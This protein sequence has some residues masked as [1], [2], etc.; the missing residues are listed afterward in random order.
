MD[1]YRVVVGASTLAA[2]LIYLAIQCLQVGRRPK[3]Y[4]PGPPTVP[5]LGNLHLLSGITP[6][7]QERRLICGQIPK[8]KPWLQFTKWAEEYGPIYSLM[9]GT[10]TYIV[11]SSPTVVKDLLDKRSNIY[12]SRPDMYIGQ[13]IAS[14]GLRL[15]VMKY[16]ATW[17]KMHRMVHNIFNMRA[18]TTYLPYQDLE[19]KQML[20]DLLDSPR[21]F[22]E[23]IRRYSNSLT[24]QM[25]FGFRTTSHTD[26]KLRQLFDC[27]E[28]WGELAAGPSSQLLDIY[29][30][31]RRLPPFL[32]PN[33]RYAQGLHKTEMELYLGH[34]MA[35][36]R[37][38]EN[39]TGK[40]CFCNDVLRV[41]DQEKMSDEQAA[42]LSGSLL[43]AGSDTTSALLVGFVQAML[44]F[45][46]VQRHAQVE[47][48]RVV[49]SAR[50][51]TMD[52]ASELPYLR[53]VVKECIRW[54]PTT[55]MAA[56]HSVT[57]EDEYMGYRIPKGATVLINVWALHMDP[58]T[59][60]SP[61]TFDPTRFGP[62]PPTEFESATASDP[63]QRRNYI[64]GAGRRVCQGMH[65][66]ERSLFLAVTRLLW[67]FD[68]KSAPGAT[69]MP[70]VDD[71]VGSL[72]V[73]P[74]PFEVTIQARTKAK[75]KMVREAWED[76]HEG[77]LDGETGQWRNVPEGM[78]FSTWMPGQEEKI[79]E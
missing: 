65:I 35:T 79:G 51:P 26:S 13:D 11:L 34:W 59:T 17:R 16:G 41:Q 58:T 38:L 56:P 20:V 46:N 37:G 63:S 15:V 6:E 1:N 7:T 73:Q 60:P 25:V 74:A 44:V 54:M 8:D 53:A 23:H 62:N 78:A 75:E 19:N 29:P 69:K 76:V 27:F 42:Y 5:V 43:E 57:Q 28:K 18:A 50:L 33:Y 70:D 24:T 49:G 77:L 40:P 66:A 2:V 36:K 39:G 32:R 14:G 72:T 12:S 3:N 47:I 67:A 64:F 21:N 61:R 48:D 52:D 22:V 30:V 31:L 55:I 45:P 68:F 9:V 4:P 10:R 71:L